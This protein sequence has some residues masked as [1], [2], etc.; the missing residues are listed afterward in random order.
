MEHEPFGHLSER[1]S[2]GAELRVAKFRRN[3]A[4]TL[5]YTFL[6][7]AVA[8]CVWL[9]ITIEPFTRGGIPSE[10]F[11]RNLFAYTLSMCGF[12]LA[13]IVTTAFVMVLKTKCKRLTE[14]LKTGGAENR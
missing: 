6:A 2:V 4:M 10:E 12:V 14:Q 1:E 7:P 5:M 13:T 9:I 8:I 3:L 11:K